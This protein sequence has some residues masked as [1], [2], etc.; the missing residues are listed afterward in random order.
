M[1]EFTPST[2]KMP[3]AKEHFP[4]FGEDWRGADADRRGTE[5]D[6]DGG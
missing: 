6:S 3:G 2:A 1:V 4:P 5:E